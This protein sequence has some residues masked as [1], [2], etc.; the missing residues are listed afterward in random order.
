MPSGDPFG[1][2]GTTQLGV[3]RVDALVAEGGFGVVYRAFHTGFQAFVALKCLKISDQARSQSNFLHGFREEAAL[4]FRLSAS[5]PAV[6]RP[7]HA[8]MLSGPNQ[9]PVPFIAF[10]WLDGQGLDRAI[11]RRASKKL[12]PLSI[13]SALSLLTPVARALALAHKF[14]SPK[15][16]VA[17]THCDLKPENIFLAVVNG[18]RVVKV[19]D[20]G[21]AKV[22]SAA[23]YEAGRMT[24]SGNERTVFTPGYGAPEQWQP[25]RFGQTGPWTDVWGL[26]LTLLETIA[27]RPIIDGDAMAMMG[28][29]C[30][31]HQRPTPRNEN[32]LVDDEVERVFAGALALH[33]RDRYRDVGAFWDALEKAVTGPG[34][35]ASTPSFTSQPL[36]LTLAPL[37]PTASPVQPIPV[38]PSPAIA[39]AD[40]AETPVSFHVVADPS[41]AAH[42]PRFE[43]TPGT[44]AIAVRTSES[45]V[46]CVASVL[47]GGVLLVANQMYAGKTGDVL[48]FGPIR[49]TWVAGGL[50]LGGMLSAVRKLT[51][52]SGTTV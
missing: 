33:P 45:W 46:L 25:K 3:Y 49:I 32:V 21:I 26:A 48:A 52:I 13:K 44:S 6:V 19:L 41:F 22:R 14:P 18:E 10:E 24:S 16:P 23:S 47:L 37:E 51:R 11:A 29:A 1:L 28:I 2:L 9:V 36:Q 43:P 42:P 38:A 40:I 7:L 17:I 5:L 8:D 35:T 39:A 15:G 12:P 4:M 50:V 27:G 31:P 20:F 30:D 34:P